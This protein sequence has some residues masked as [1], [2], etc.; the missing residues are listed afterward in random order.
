MNTLSEPMM[1]EHLMPYLTVEDVKRVAS[2]C[3]QMDSFMMENDYG[4]RPHYLALMARI[5]K[6]PIHLP[7]SGGQW[8]FWETFFNATR[9]PCMP[10]PGRVYIWM[11][12]EFQRIQREDAETLERAGLRRRLE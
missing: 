12:F 2:T 6:Y 11:N 4:W 9:I 3:T 1:V 8:D 5:E 7:S 10:D